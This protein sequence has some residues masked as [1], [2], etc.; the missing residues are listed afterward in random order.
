M[1]RSL[2]QFSVLNLSSLRLFSIWLTTLA[3]LF[4]CTVRA[5][6]DHWL[7]GY[8]AIYDLNGTM[9][10]AQVDM[11]KLTHVIYWGVEPTSSGGVNTTKYVSAATFASGATGV[12]TQ[13]HAAGAKAL[14]G[15]GG[16]AYD[17]YSLA[18]NEATTPA[19]LPTF[20]G[21]IVALMQEDGGFDG[22]DINWEQIG[23]YPG[24]NTQFPAFIAA[25]RTA[26]NA[27]TPKPLLT[28]SPETQANGG[29]PDLIGPINQDFDQIN[30]QTYLMSGPY[31]GAETWHNSP[32]SNGGL[33]YILDP[34]EAL[35]SVTG[36]VAAY[37]GDGIPIAKLGMGIQFG[38]LTWLGGTGTSTGGATK[39]EQTWTN[40]NSPAYCSAT[41]P[42]AP[43]L[44]YPLYTQI[45]PL[46]TAAPGNGYTLTQDTTV[47]QAWLSYDPSG[48]GTTNEAKDE[49]IS[50][51]NPSSI[52]KK[53]QDLSAGAGLGGTMGGVMLFELSGDYFPSAAT[54]QQHPLL[55]AANSM[56]S[57]L[58]GA[59]TGLTITPGTGNAA[60]K[61]NAAPFATQY[62]VYYSTT[63][64]S[65][66]TLGATVTTTST[67][68]L[69]LTEGDEYYFQVQPFNSFGEATGGVATGNATISGLETPTVTWATPASVPYGTVL[70]A[71]QLNATASV[72]G[73]FVYSP[74]AG[75]LPAVGTDTLSVTFTPTSAS[76]SKVT[77]M[78]SLV[79]TAATLSTSDNFGSVNAGST[80][81]AHTISAT[82]IGDDGVSAQV[83]TMGV[84]G[85]DFK[86]VSAISCSHSGDIVLQTTCTIDVDFTP[87]AVGQRLGAVLFNV[88]N[89]LEKTNTYGSVYLSGTGIAPFVA[90]DPGGPFTINIPS[91]ISPYGT[92]I[93]GAGNIYFANYDAKD[94]LKVPPF[95]TSSTYVSGLSG[96][97]TALAL[98]GAG[99]LYVAQNTSVLLVN[100]AGTVTT[101]ASGLVD[102]KG[103]AVDANG[104]VYI[105]NTNVNSVLRYSPTGEQ[106]TVLTSTA[107]IAGKKL[108]FPT[109]LAV[110]ASGNVYVSD[111]GNNRILEVPSSGTPTVLNATGL[112]TPFGIGI[113]P[114]GNLFIADENN[115]RIVRLTPGGVQ[116]T[117]LSGSVLDINLSSPIAVSTDSYENLYV[118]DFGN[119][120]L[121]EVGRL[122]G[123]TL[124]F[125]STEVGSTSSP[126]TVTLNNIGNATL[127]FTVPS[128]GTNPSVPTGFKLASGTTC[129]NQTTASTIGTLAGGSSCN[130]AVSFA[131]PGAG[132]TYGSLSITDNSGKQMFEVVGLGVGGPVTATVTL[133]NL[134]ATY[135]GS[136]ISATATTNPAGLAVNFTYNG[137]STPPTHAGSYAVVATVTSTG[138]T[139]TGTGTLVIAKATPVIN[140]PVPAP[141]TTATC[142]LSST[143]LDATAT[144]GT[145]SVTG[146]F[147]YTPPAGTLLNSGTYTLE[148]SFTPADTTDFNTATGSV[149]FV[150]G[151]TDQIHFT[152]A[153]FGNQ[154]IGTSST[155]HTITLTISPADS[156]NT[157]TPVQVLTL[158]A[159]GPGT[160]FQNGGGGTCVGGPYTNGAKCD[161]NVTFTPT[162]AGTRLGAV[163]LMDTNGN[164]AAIAYL[165]GTGVGP[166]I[167][168]DP[169]TASQISIPHQISPFG[170][171]VDGAGNVYFAD[172]TLEVV[173]K[174]TP[175]GAYSTYVSGLTQE[176]AALTVDGAGNLYVTQTTSVLEVTPNGVQTK[177]PGTF[178]NPKGLAVDNQGDL[179][180]GNTVDNNI[181]EVTPEGVQTTVLSGKVLG[182]NLL[183]PTGVAVDLAGDL[184]ISDSGNNRILELPAGGS[185]K[186][187]LGTGLS[188][189]WGIALSD[190]GN[191]YIANEDGGS[192][193]KV[194]STGVVST[195]L[196]SALGSTLNMPIGI[197]VD[198][199]ENLYF[200]DTGNARVIKINR[201][202]PALAFATTVLGSPSSDSPKTLT[203]NNIGNANLTFPAP[204]TG[205]NGALSSVQGGFGLLSTTT[206]PEI[207]AGGAAVSVAGGSSCKYVLSFAPTKNPGAHSGLLSLTDNNLNVA[208]AKQQIGMTGT[209]TAAVPATVQLSGLTPTY[210]GSPIPVTATTTPVGLTVS[211][212]Y[213]GSATA[214]TTVGS[215]AIVA[216]ITAAGYSGSATGTEV[217]SKATPVI[218]WPALT[219][220]TAPFALTSTQ[221]DAKATNGAVTVA[222]TYA[223]TPTSG[224]VL[225]AGTY[226]LKVQFTPTDTPDYNTPAVASQTLVV[227][228]ATAPP[229]VVWVPDFYGDVLQV[230][231][232]TTTPTAITID[233][234]TCNPN[235]VAVNNNL[236]Y[237]ACSYDKW[238]NTN[239]DK[240]LVYNASTI[241]SAPAGVLT[242]SPEQVISSTQFSSL[243]GIA[244]DASNNLWI[245][246][247]G[248]S[249]VEMIS[250]ATLNTATPVV[251][252]ELVG[253]PNNPAGLTFAPDGSL[254]VTGLDGSGQGILL[255]FAPSQFGLGEGAS[256]SYC[257]A[258]ESG[259]GCQYVSGLF[260]NDPEGV[261]LVGSDIWVAD[262][263]TGASGATPGRQLINLSVTVTGTP[264]AMGTMAV[265]ETFG[266]TTVAADSL[267]VCPGG[268]FATPG[269]LW[270][271]DESYGEGDPQCGSN[272][273]VAT[274][275]GGVFDF[276]AAQLA[277]KT[278]TASQVLAYSGITGRP[279][280]GGIFVENDQ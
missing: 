273:D 278:T 225:A 165:N 275:T 126:Q 223:Y 230:R 229:R 159:S 3:L 98:D 169:G 249:Q 154:N 41:N 13:A 44:G 136:P 33:D 158:G 62:K 14:I 124:N 266:S 21:N 122:F 197:A 38:G 60:L 265:N 121:L 51:D 106:S 81:L 199:A 133:G 64:G 7:T 262:N 109:G 214:P 244:F 251:T 45:A 242:I 176:P 170:V 255:N 95:G 253:S 89:T 119:G 143:Q 181:V 131:P 77:K 54:G 150:V 114:T 245:A 151:K 175:A 236:L 209:A 213:N 141:V 65:A 157:D 191:L 206:C 4:G 264:T 87:M 211:I 104:N 79:V 210:T 271:N 50:Y 148:T 272:G 205:N 30:L 69:N 189:P 82:F 22:V 161:V 36:A 76:Y 140:W 56:Q 53:G 204:T 142:T 276:T 35:P 91:Q 224:T 15:I 99:N 212:T 93:D 226:T 164:A 269:H 235:S 67:T 237:V 186:L 48:T 180:V 155:A 2:R 198:S 46:A 85:L 23:Y 129:P 208:N 182:T 58:P 195:V 105:A 232:G 185:P 163:V 187:V 24:D 100:P 247:N 128:S 39:P 9:T 32:Y 97:P 221:L 1:P 147:V 173:Y 219:A 42:S 149:S 102:P 75:T 184:Y 267:L 153:S 241:R 61:W 268:L 116:T 12:V 134:S 183:Y 43:T 113:G 125:A 217:I 207:A 25:L 40:D 168:Y 243:V 200:T 263:S 72:P 156:L 108:S 277:A 120:R 112:N 257:M 218:T 240:I 8:L 96:A 138:Y 90:F 238:Q 259:Q 215:Y 115:N 68:I 220:V 92:A 166:Q 78:V 59:V 16:D 201:A 258:S 145:A 194:S 37:T 174:V 248:N 177:F 88:V 280:F 19:N 11:T 86:A 31:C 231:V 188:S 73:N 103:I 47:D 66:G 26:L 28:M 261:A 94:I 190:T 29:R 83:M 228:A 179:F 227:N 279:G 127:D 144:F 193:V 63:S 256:P 34:T 123:G 234:P 107:V 80:S 111:S 202:L 254:W 274:E 252:V 260:L 110:D 178:Q 203:V 132:I 49:F 17:G 146:T 167:A 239:P 137:S 101:F 130:Y 162:A 216:T 246:S 52:A 10:P 84:S 18:F 70:T 171:T 71:T 6:E 57:L 233:L 117:L 222:G 27:L 250:A 172:Q 55:T 20:V 192:I 152:S 118:S 139:G 196:T 135:T 74:A 270:V 5:Q 160:D